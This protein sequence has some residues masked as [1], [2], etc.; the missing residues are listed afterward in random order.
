MYL[1]RVK[2]K[3]RTYLYLK[4]YCVREHYE[5][6]SV[7]I[8][9]FGRIEKALKTMY[10]WKNDHSTIPQELIQEG[11][12]R[13]DLMTWINTLETGIHKRSGRSFV[14]QHDIYE[15]TN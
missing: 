14:Y 5:S 12:S 8:F 6:K 3:G 13:N 15:Y 11:C 4:K 2:A 1:E 7:T 9:A 10:K